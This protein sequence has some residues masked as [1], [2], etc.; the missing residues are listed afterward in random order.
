MG[1]G[2][3]GVGGEEAWGGGGHCKGAFRDLVRGYL[4]RVGVHYLER[5]GGQVEPSAAVAPPPLP[6]QTCEHPHPPS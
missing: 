3:G 5:E 6:H 1:G 2:E 4:E